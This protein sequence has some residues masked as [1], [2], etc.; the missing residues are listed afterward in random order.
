MST[1][2]SGEEIAPFFGFIGAAAALIFSCMSCSQTLCC[3]TVMFLISSALNDLLVC[4][5]NAAVT[6][7]WQGP[8]CP[9]RS[10]IVAMIKQLLIWLVLPAAIFLFC[11]STSLT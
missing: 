1:V 6:L 7:K 4:T 5:N 9:F 11:H 10:S 2:V 8:C 3:C